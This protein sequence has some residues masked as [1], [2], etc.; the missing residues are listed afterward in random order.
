MLL[1]VLDVCVCVRFYPPI[2]INDAPN[3]TMEINERSIM[4]LIHMAVS[5]WRSDGSCVF[6]ALHYTIL[7]CN[8]WID[9][10]RYTQD[11]KKL[12][13]LFLV[14][15]F[16]VDWYYILCGCTFRSPTR[17]RMENITML[18]TTILGYFEQGN[19]QSQC[20]IV[21]SKDDPMSGRTTG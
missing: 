2:H 5:K 3:T 4:K 1:G 8:D 18:C 10:S 15:V 11:C 17:T 21:D 16:Q 19:G 12:E 20:S 7:D 13:V 6:Y 14:R 9:S